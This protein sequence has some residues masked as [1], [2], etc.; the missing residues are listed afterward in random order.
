[1]TQRSA[2]YPLARHSHF[3]FFWRAAVAKAL[4]DKHNFESANSPSREV[5]GKERTL[6]RID[7]KAAGLTRYMGSNK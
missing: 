1:M 3:R 7:R 5:R 6:A 2:R 4:L